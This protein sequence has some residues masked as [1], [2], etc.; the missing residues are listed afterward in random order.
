MELREL[1]GQIFGGAEH[2][3]ADLRVGFETPQKRRGGGIA[4]YLRNEE[5]DRSAFV[6]LT[7]K[8]VFAVADGVAQTF[9][10]LGGRLWD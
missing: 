10:G 6:G 9:G 5:D 4:A 2:H 1:C 8:S 3:A 7:V